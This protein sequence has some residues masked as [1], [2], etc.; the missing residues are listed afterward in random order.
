MWVRS[1]RVG[2]HE[3][4]QIG[5][6]FFPFE[7]RIAVAGRR[8]EKREEARYGPE[9][10]GEDGLPARIN[11]GVYGLMGG[12]GH[13]GDITNQLLANS[14]IE[15]VTYRVV[16]NQGV[17]DSAPS[18]WA[19]QTLALGGRAP[20]TVLFPIKREGKLLTGEVASQ[21]WK[22]SPFAAKVAKVATNSLKLPA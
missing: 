19:R 13:D 20:L 21:E 4:K 1:V 14:E 6:P 3:G 2:A 12:L 7:A 5:P 15:F 16:F 17:F 11:S 10:L 18:L 8:I 22:I 9:I